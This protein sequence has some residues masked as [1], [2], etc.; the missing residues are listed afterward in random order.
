MAYEVNV[1]EAN[2]RLKLTIP[3]GPADEES[4]ARGADSERAAGTCIDA[5]EPFIPLCKAL[6]IRKQI[7]AAA[8]DRAGEFAKQIMTDLPPNLEQQ[9]EQAVRDWV[10]KKL[11]KVT[12]YGLAKRLQSYANYLNLVCLVRP[13]ELDSF[14]LITQPPRRGTSK[15]KEVMYTRYDNQPTLVQVNAH[16]VPHYGA[17]NLRDKLIAKEA[18]YITKQLIANKASRSLVE[19]GLRAFLQTAQGDPELRAVEAAAKALNFKPYQDYQVGKCDLASFY[20]VRPSRSSRAQPSVRVASGFVQGEDNFFYLG[21]KI[22][23]PATMCILPLESHFIF[24][25][26]VE[27]DSKA[28]R[29]RECGFSDTLGVSAAMAERAGERAAGAAATGSF[30]PPDFTDDVHVGPG[31]G[32]LQAGAWTGAAAYEGQR[33]SGFNPALTTVAESA[34]WVQQQ[35]SGPASARAVVRK[36][37]KNKWEFEGTSTGESVPVGSNDS[38]PYNGNVVLDSELTIPD[39][40]SGTYQLKMEITVQTLSGICA[41]AAG[42]SNGSKGGGGN[43]YGN[44]VSESSPRLLTYSFTAE[45]EAR[46]ASFNFNLY[47]SSGSRTPSSCR[48]KGSIELIVPEE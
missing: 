48:A 35:S 12:L 14:Y 16:L 10:A 23:T 24:S 17:N 41:L 8:A 36:T 26:K 40:L 45:N 33:P 1:R 20:P 15:L 30:A 13:I 5:K 47:A 19:A 25:E 39:N 43:N 22:H 42:I 3:S 2:S 38:I 9:G 46:L 31:E 4:E 32:L 34:P 11:A 7:E 6:N 18:A 28:R 21:S 44:G 27:L 37:G 29:K